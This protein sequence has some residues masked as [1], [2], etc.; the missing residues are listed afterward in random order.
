MFM[1]VHVC[2]HQNIFA[3]FQCLYLFLLYHDNGHNHQVH[4][5]QGRTQQL[6][7]VHLYGKSRLLAVAAE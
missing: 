3:L 5:V 6:N 4:V 1:N 2:V 7:S